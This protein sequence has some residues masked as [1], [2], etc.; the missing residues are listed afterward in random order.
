[1][2]GL[3]LEIR[4]GEFLAIHGHSGS[5]KTTLLSLIGGLTRPTS[6]AVFVAGEDLSRLDEARLAAVR[7]RTIGFVFQFASLVPTLTALENVLLPAAFSQARRRRVSRR[8]ACGFCPSSG[9]PTSSSAYP[10]QLSGGQQR[11]V[12]IARAFILDPRLILADEPTGDLDLE[13]EE[14][15]LGLFREMHRRGV[16]IVMVTHEREITKDADR[17]VTMD[18][19]KILEETKKG[20]ALTDLIPAR[21][22]GATIGSTPR[23]GLL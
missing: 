7:Y 1:M 5:G 13:T 12:A 21:R 14:E 11:R 19:G 4:C 18:H 2:E 17:V 15:V 16:T 10:G 20:E 6:G 23:E 8:R 3:S 22:I 9:S